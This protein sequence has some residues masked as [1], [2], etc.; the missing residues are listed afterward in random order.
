MR[1]ALGIEYD[2][3]RFS[4]WQRQSHRPSVQAALEQALSRVADHAVSVN[5]AGR[6]DAGVH[7]TQ[8]V[9]HF[10]TDSPRPPQAWIRGVNS[11]L[12][13]VIRVIWMRAVAPE[14][15]ARFAATARTYRYVILSRPVQSA[16]QRRRVAWTWQR[17]ELA[18]M[19][20]AAQYL[21]GEH[22]FSSYRALACQA[23]HPVRTLHRLDITRCGDYFYVDV[24]AN[25]FLHHMVRN[26]AGVLLSIGTGA[27]PPRWSW[28]IL[29]ARDRTAGGITAPAGGLYLVS[30]RYPERF[31]IPERGALPVFA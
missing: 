28:E 23:R 15:H 12:P 9:V 14:F 10:D 1:I 22:D 5:C 26:I 19:R 24:E 4:G 25:A 8:Q 20:A 7:A 17:L 11:N 18:P 13:D 27:H 16:L 3:T 2:G 21:L 29:Q 6:T 31:A 30:V